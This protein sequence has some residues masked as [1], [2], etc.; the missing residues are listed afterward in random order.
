M[1][2]GERMKLRRKELG[3]NVDDVAV[4]IGKDRATVY[5]YEGSEIENMPI[6]VLAPLAKAL[7]TTPAYLMG[8]EDNPDAQPQ[9]TLPG[10]T[11]EHLS[12]SPIQEKIISNCQQLNE[13]GQKKV[14]DFSDDLVSSNNYV[15]TDRFRIAAYGADETEENF[16]L[17]DEEIIT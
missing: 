7:D 3:M 17:P 14:L 15:A 11:G 12:L 10:Q 16:Q 9:T 2:V 1:T 5:R 13:T 8:W 4:R 6:G